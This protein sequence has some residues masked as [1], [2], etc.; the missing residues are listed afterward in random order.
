M[1]NHCN[2]HADSFR[3]DINLKFIGAQLSRKGLVGAPHPNSFKII[4]TLKKEQNRIDNE[5]RILRPGQIANRTKEQ[6]QRDENE[7]LEKLKT[8]NETGGEVSL[9]DI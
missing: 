7:S 2:L 1:L 6:A 8:L 4:A 3:T 5:R 9:S